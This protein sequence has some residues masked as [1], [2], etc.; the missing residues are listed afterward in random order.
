MADDY[1]LFNVL[2]F[3][4]DL[5]GK[6][7]D[8]RNAV[9][10]ALDGL[11]DWI[12][13]WALKPVY[14][15]WNTLCDEWTAMIEATQ[16]L[17]DNLGEAWTLRAAATSWRTDFE[18]KMT[19]IPGGVAP[20]QLSTEDVFS[21]AS[22]SAYRSVIPGQAAAMNAIKPQYSTKVADGLDDIADAINKCLSTVQ[23]ALVA[24]GVAVAGAIVAIAGAAT[25]IALVGGI[26]TC[27]GGIATYLVK[28]MNARD[29]IGTDC[30]AV[31]SSWEGVQTDWANFD[32]QKW[33]EAT[34]KI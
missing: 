4:D 11:P 12:P 30:Q 5:Q 34:T 29:Q 33:P 23:E 10:S 16:E 6:I 17:L 25:V 20:G 21:G 8:L 27:I 7:E 28:M 1:T 19:D 26:V 14:N 32:G 18:A 31:Q 2:N 13:D 9:N 24:Y 22:A 3:L 15:E